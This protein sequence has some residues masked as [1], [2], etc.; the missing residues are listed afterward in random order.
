MRMDHQVDRSSPFNESCGDFEYMIISRLWPKFTKVYGDKESCNYSLLQKEFPECNDAML[1]TMIK[2]FD[3]GKRLEK[4]DV[5]IPCRFDDVQYLIPDELRPKAGSFGVAMCKCEA[6]RKYF[7]VL[8]FQFSKFRDGT[9][10]LLCVKC[11][12]EWQQSSMG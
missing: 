1:W 2:K 12:T 4:A 10:N 7:T 8:E 5:M 3:N 11:Q 9:G 6:C